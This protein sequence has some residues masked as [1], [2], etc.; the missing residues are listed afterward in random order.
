MIIEDGNEYEEFARAFL[1]DFDI[2]AAHSAQEAL[3]TLAA[4]EGE[5]DAHCAGL[6]VDLRFERSAVVDLVGDVAEEAR[7]RFGGD[8]HRAV[9]HLKEQQGTL[10]LAELRARG[11]AMVAVFVHDFSPR[12]LANLRR[13]YG[14]VE[15]VP[16]F[17]A[18]A[19]RS[20]FGAAP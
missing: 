16:S 17:D 19:I 10:I 14:A 9:R 8:R 5:A 18:A 15:A 2:R 4:I 11:H 1:T 6:L 3:A 13:L 20:A 7:R 12:R